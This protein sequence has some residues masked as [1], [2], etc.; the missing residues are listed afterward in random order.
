MRMPAWS[1]V[2]EMM[3]IDWSA[4]DRAWWMRFYRDGRG[5]APLAVA[6][7]DQETGIGVEDLCLFGG[8]LEVEGGFGPLGG[9]CIWADG[10][11]GLRGGQGL[12]EFGEFADVEAEL[13]EG[14]GHGF[15]F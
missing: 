11:I 13:E 8:G 12:D 14:V 5:L 2:R 15:Q 7:E 1:F 3:T 6:A 10:G 4:S 9:G